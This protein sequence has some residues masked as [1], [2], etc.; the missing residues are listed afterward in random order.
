MITLPDGVITHQFKEL[1]TPYIC[2]NLNT[3]IQL[4]LTKITYI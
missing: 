1:K 4:Y 2:S 3:L